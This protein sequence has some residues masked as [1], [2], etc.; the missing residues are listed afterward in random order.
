MRVAV[1]AGLLAPDGEK[2]SVTISMGVAERAESMEHPDD[3]L[4]AADEML[5]AAKQ[6]GRDR[7]CAAGGGDGP[8]TRDPEHG[9]RT[10]RLRLPLIGNLDGLPVRVMVVDDDTQAR[11]LYRRILEREGYVVA[12]ASDGIEAIEMVP[13]WGPDVIVLDAMMPRLD[14]LGCA[15]W[16]KA[17]AATQ[18]IPLIMLSAADDAKDIEAALEAGVDE[19]IT[20]P[21]RHREFALRVRS[22]SRLHRGKAEL[23]WSNQRRWE[24][25]RALQ[26]LLDLSVGLLSIDSIA[27]ILERT[28]TAVAELMR[29]RRVSIMLPDAERAHLTIRASTGIDGDVAASVRVPVG[30]PIAGQVFLSGEQVVINGTEETQPQRGRYDSQCFVSAPLMCKA[31]RA[32]ERVVG[33]LNITERHGQRPFEE[34]ELEFL[35]LLSG[36]VAAAIADRMSR[37]ER[38]KAQDSIVAGLA[39]LAEYHDADTGSHLDRVTRYA[40]ILADGLRSMPQYREWIDPGYLDLLR[41]AMPL[42]DIGKV[43]VPD[44]ILRKPGRLTDGEMLQIRRHSEIGARTIQSIRRRLPDASFLQMA[45]EIAHGHHERWDGTGYPQGIGGEAIPL[46]ARIAALADVY[47]ALRARRAYKGAMPH[48]KAV[49]IIRQGAGSQFDPTVVEVFLA[50]AGEFARIASALAVSVVASEPLELVT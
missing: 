46:S 12:E 38:D 49:T 27:G 19:Y 33:V 47:D 45:E 6:A 1:A 26:V 2:W 29:C 10:E 41:R 8:A 35:D 31:L 30:D 15:R 36:F 7:V 48:D 32:S 20:K 44:Q 16:L 50:R 23:L 21:P 34:S 11:A 13:N 3:L 9:E 28:T 22:M 18:D 43:A 24:Q 5:Y 40:L 17:R 42:H 4:K 14:G 39:T 25:T 37:Q